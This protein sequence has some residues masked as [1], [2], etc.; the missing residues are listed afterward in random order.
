MCNLGI[1]KTFSQLMIS[2][3]LSPEQLALKKKNDQRAF[4]LLKAIA[5]TQI[6]SSQDL[7]SYPRLAS[8]LSENKS[9]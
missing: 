2:K 4:A 5:A 7:S 8:A 6:S 9:K 3:S 1:Q